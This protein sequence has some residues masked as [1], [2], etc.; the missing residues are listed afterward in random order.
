MTPKKDVSKV[1]KEGKRASKKDAGKPKVKRALTPYFMFAQENREKV[2]VE[3]GFESKQLGEIAK[4]GRKMEEPVRRGEAVLRQ[5][6][7]GRQEKI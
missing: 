1:R 3:F 7:R 2:K 6:K 5:A 4:V